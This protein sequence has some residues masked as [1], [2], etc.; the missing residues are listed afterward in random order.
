MYKCGTLFSDGTMLCWLSLTSS[1]ADIMAGIVRVSFSQGVGRDAVL[2][3]LFLTK[4]ADPVCEEQVQYRT[5]ISSLT[6]N[7]NTY[8][9]IDRVNGVNDQRY[10]CIKVT[11][12]GNKW[13][14]IYINLESGNRLFDVEKTCTRNINV[15]KLENTQYNIVRSEEGSLSITKDIG[16]V[17]W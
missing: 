13:E 2:E 4:I 12:P 6:V 14:P 10:T 9:V 11:L 8:Q 16:V 5:P 15:T 7:C 3:S 17:P 1:G